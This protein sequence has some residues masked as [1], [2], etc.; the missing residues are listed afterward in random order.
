MSK[1]KDIVAAIEKVAPP[2]LKESWDNVGLQIGDPEMQVSRILLALT[3]SQQVIEEAVKKEVDLVVTH[4]P[5]IFKGVKSL[6]A[7]QTIGK[8][9]TQCMKHDVA[10]F[11][12]HTNLDIAVG[13]V[14]DTLASCLGLQEIQGL[15]VVAEKKRFKL[16]V[17][18]PTTHLEQV[19]TAMFQAGAGRQGAY[20]NCAWESEGQGQFMPS[21]WA[22]PFLGEIGKLEKVC[23]GRI[24]VLVDEENLSEVLRAMNTAHP[25]E[26]VAY[27][28]F[29]NIAQKQ[30]E[31]IG[32][33]G[34]LSHE[35]TLKKWLEDVKEA[36]N[37]PF[38]SY[39]G[40]LDR[41]IRRVALCGGSAASYLQ[42]AKKCGADVY[43]TGDV[44][45]HDAQLAEE[46]D[47]ALVDVS[48]FA[49]ERPVLQA[50]KE[51]ILKACSKNVE[52]IISEDEKDF[53]Q[54][55]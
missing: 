39:T 29:E 23:E 3:P 2:S 55:C 31:S 18:V 11:C 33:V 1:V 22:Q 50:I 49:G 19:K 24:E 16:V 26:E 41:P 7:D 30:T 54:Y 37:I 9:A 53:I 13:G 12:A 14:N 21:S 51:I 10:I 45:Y 34:M 5:F 46:L 25:Y 17:F 4:H 20:E 40:T 35:T 28:V 47:I 43:V 15:S 6:R 8:L 42:D 36:L 52:V 44:K 27:D 38:V 48:H 32:R